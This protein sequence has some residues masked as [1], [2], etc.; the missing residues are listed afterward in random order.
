MY[1]TRMHPDDARVDLMRVDDALLRLRR[2]WT[3]PPPALVLEPLVGEPVM[4]SSVLV[5]EACARGG[6]EIGVGEVAQFLDVDP[7]TASR[8]VDRAARSGFVER[9]SSR[10]DA[11]RV[12]VVL[13]PSGQALRARAVDFR[14][15]WL[16]TVLEG[17][18][19]AE[20]GVLAAAL[21]RFAD[22]VG[23]VGPPGEAGPVGGE[24]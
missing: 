12:A 9:R 22:A 15:D 18:G 4:M 24:A 10:V 21:T 5:V 11:R 14:L 8:L 19:D 6:N 23:E 13:T 2:L 3:S 16:S 20:V 1:G 17:W 7:S